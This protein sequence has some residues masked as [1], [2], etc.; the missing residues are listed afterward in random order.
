MTARDEAADYYAR[1]EEDFATGLRRLP[2]HPISIKLEFT[3]PPQPAGITP[4]AKSAHRGRR[5]D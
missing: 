5:F 4:E 3:F 1:L 2:V